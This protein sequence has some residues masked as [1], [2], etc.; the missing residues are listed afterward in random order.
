MP[1][2]PYMHVERFGNDEVQG[3]ELGECY[4][5][6]K[7]DG[8]N[9]SVW[10][11]LDGIQAGSR[12]RHLSLD[13]DNA[14]FYAWAKSSA[15]LAA[16]FADNEGLRLYGEWLVPHTLKTYREDAW[17]KFYVFDVFDDM[18]GVYLPYNVYSELCFVHELDIIPPLCIMR[19]ATHDNL[20]IELKNNEYLIGQGKGSGE[21]I[22]IK[23]YDFLNKYRRVVWAKICTNEFKDKHKRNEPTVKNMKAL[24]ESAIC[25][26]YVTQH[27]VDKVYAKIVNEQEGWNSKYIPRLLGTVFYDLVNEET[28]NIVKKHKNPTIDFKKLNTLSI[29][30]VKELRPELF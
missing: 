11:N 4:V 16:F 25:D 29:M 26:G 15:E 27:L 21:G 18:N 9:A 3:I 17:R 12:K 10:W 28:W 14:G 30:K 20:L 6:P 13:A 5:F 1:F 23:N 22:V 2:R 8:T 7:L 19:N 24:V